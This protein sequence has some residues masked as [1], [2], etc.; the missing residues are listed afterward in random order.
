M[1]SN[2]VTI[3]ATSKAAHVENSTF[4]QHMNA[5]AISILL[6]MQGSSDL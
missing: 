1:Q 5:D 6:I 4:D 2:P 3:S